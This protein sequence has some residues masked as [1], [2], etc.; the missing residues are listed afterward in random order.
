MGATFST[1]SSVN[2][3]NLAVINFA[4]G[5]AEIPAGD[6]DLIE[7]AA[8]ALKSAPKGTMIE[9]GG[10]TDS[11]GD[12]ASNVKLSEDRA[13]AVRQALIAAGV[14][15]SMLVAKGYG[16]AKHVASNDT[17]YG[18][19]RNRRIEYAALPAAAR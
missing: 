1:D 13:N 5:S 15:G 19:F 8:V 2:A 7:R 6:R 17:E 4:T 16:D 3:M 14:D 11:T 12:P 9:I 18:R 10:H